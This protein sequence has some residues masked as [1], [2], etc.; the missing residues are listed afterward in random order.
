MVEAVGHQ[1]VSLWYFSV[2]PHQVYLLALPFFAL[3]MA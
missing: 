3:V 2:R 1:Y